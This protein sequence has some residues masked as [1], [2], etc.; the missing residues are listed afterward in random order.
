MNTTKLSMKLFQNI[1][2]IIILIACVT[3]L[4][5]TGYSIYPVIIIILQTITLIIN[6]HKK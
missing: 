6:N 4:L 5:R 2:G 1:F 3:S